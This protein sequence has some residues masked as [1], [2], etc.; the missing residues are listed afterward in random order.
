MTSV[1]SDLRVTGRASP[2][3]TNPRIQ[4]VALTVSALTQLCGIAE[5]ATLVLFVILTVVPSRRCAER[6]GECCN[7]GAGALIAN[8]GSG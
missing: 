5:V 8:F 6:F 2:S 1:P 3:L 4:D 7:E